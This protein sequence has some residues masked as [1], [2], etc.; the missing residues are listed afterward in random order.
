MADIPISEGTE[1]ATFADDTAVL[2]PHL[3][4]S[5]AVHNLQEAIYE[6]T[7]KMKNQV[8]QRKIRLYRLHIKASSVHSYLY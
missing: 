5:A 6:W 4:Y 2:A 8:K 3:D 1:I 7:K